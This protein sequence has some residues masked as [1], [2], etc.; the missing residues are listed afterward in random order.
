MYNFNISD[1]RRA[2]RFDMFEP[3]ALRWDVFGSRT[4]CTVFVTSVLNFQNT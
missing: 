1:G 2:S 4:S 3:R